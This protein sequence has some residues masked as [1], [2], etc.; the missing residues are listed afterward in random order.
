MTNTTNAYD[1]VIMDIDGC[2]IP[3]TPDSFDTESLVEIFRYQRNALANKDRPKLTVCTGRPQ[4]FAESI[5]RLLG[6]SDVPCVA[7]NGVWLFHPGTNGYM[8]DPNITVDDRKAVAEAQ[9]ELIRRFG[10]LGFTIQPGKA[11]SVSL[12]HPER[13]NLLAAVPAVRKIAE[14]EGWP[15]RISTTVCYI[16]CDLIHVSKATGIDRLLEKYPVPKSRLAGIGD[17]TGDKYI[18]DH[19]AFFAC[20]ANADEEIRKRADYISPY[21]E[22]KGVIDI[23]DRLK[24]G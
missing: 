16:N 15:F 14:D 20:P 23:L 2:L 22:A 1:L 24:G 12:Y 5:C 7:E 13:E 3:E 4:P 8:I 21:P 10:P 9:H 19:C 11:A 6:N 17:T 18:A